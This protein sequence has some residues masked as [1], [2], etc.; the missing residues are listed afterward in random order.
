[1]TLKRRPVERNFLPI[2]HIYNSFYAWER[3]LPIILTNIKIAAVHTLEGVVSAPVPYNGD[4]RSIFWYT[5]MK[6]KHD[7]NAQ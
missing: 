5:D 3:F 2:L 1:M 7:L 6:S 4:K